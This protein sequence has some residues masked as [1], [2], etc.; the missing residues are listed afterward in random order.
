MKIR[1]VIGAAMA[2]H[3]GQPRDEETTRT[4][5]VVTPCAPPAFTAGH[6]DLI[7][8]PVYSNLYDAT[9]RDRA[10]QWGIWLTPEKC[11]QIEAMAVGDVLT[12]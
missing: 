12:V 3:K 9:E 11:D 6:N 8:L 5:E 1:K 10:P 2:A 7:N 4:I